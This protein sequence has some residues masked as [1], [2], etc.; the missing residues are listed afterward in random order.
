MA[1]SNITE[2]RNF[3]EKGLKG[4]IVQYVIEAYIKDKLYPNT[5][6]HNYN[7]I[8]EIF[9]DKRFCTQLEKKPFITRGIISNLKKRNFIPTNL[10]NNSYTKEIVKQTLRQLN[11]KPIQQVLGKLIS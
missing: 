9:R 3:G 5:C 11:I 8:E 6:T 10:P 4:V 1:I 7:Q 2:K